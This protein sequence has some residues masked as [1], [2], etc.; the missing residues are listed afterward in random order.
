MSS[1]PN[2]PETESYACPKCP[3]EGFKTLGAVRTHF[4]A[5]DHDLHCTICNGDFPTVKSFVAHH[6]QKHL[7]SGK[8]SRP[9]RQVIAKTAAADSKNPQAT[10]FPNQEFI[11]TAERTALEYLL[12]KR[13]IVQCQL[14]ERPATKPTGQGPFKKANQARQNHSTPS[15]LKSSSHA[16]SFSTSSIAVVDKIRM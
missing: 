6:R 2:L 9:P 4:S 14:P 16:R 8:P 5:K 10:M 13:Q 12:P 15:V 1:T 11:E 7:N 3:K